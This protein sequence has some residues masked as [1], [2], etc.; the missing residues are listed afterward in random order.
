MER[1]QSREGDRAE[2]RK[3]ERERTDGERLGEI[4]KKGWEMIWLLLLLNE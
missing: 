3:T 1:R 2:L 4:E